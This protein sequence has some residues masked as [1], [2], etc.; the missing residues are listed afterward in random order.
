MFQ[1]QRSAGIKL[2]RLS[3]GPCEWPRTQTIGCLGE[4]DGHGLSGAVGD[5]TCFPGCGLDAR[6]FHRDWEGKS[7]FE[8]W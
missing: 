1:E 8:C 5:G 7:M 6:S 4:H 3:T 2:C